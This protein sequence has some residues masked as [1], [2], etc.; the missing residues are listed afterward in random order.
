MEEL[1]P[2]QLWKK[3]VIEFVLVFA[4]IALGF[5]A[6]NMR[7]YFAKKTEEKEFVQS[8]IANL[9]VDS[10][11]YAK[12]DSAVTPRQ[13]LSACLSPKWM[14]AGWRVAKPDCRPKFKLQSKAERI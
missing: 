13:E 12:R 4:A 5:F 10:V 7:E 6:E 2:E 9:E 8:L 14:C 3:Y 1:K 11:A